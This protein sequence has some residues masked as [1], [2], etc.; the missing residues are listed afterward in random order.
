MM[1]QRAVFYPRSGYMCSAFKSH[2]YTN[3]ALKGRYQLIGHRITM[4]NILFILSGNLSTT[5]RARKNIRAAAKYY[6]V[7]VL[8]ANRHPAWDKLDENWINS[9]D[10]PVEAVHLGRRPFFPWLQATLLHKLAGIAWYIFPKSVFLNAYASQKV[11]IQL[12]KQAKCLAFRPDLVVGQGGGALYPAYKFARK[13]RIPFAVDVEDYHPG[14]SSH[15]PKGH[16][17]KRRKFLL[18]TILPHAAF[19][20][21]ASPL[22]KQYTLN[23]AERPPRNYFLLNNA[24]PEHEFISARPVNDEKLQLVWF[25]QNIDHGRGLE[26]VISAVATY[27]DAVDLT[28]IGNARVQFI[29]EWLEPHKDYVF[30][31]DPKPQ[32]ELHT[33]LSNFDVGLATEISDCDINKDIALSNKIFAYAQAGLYILAT[34]TAGQKLF[35]QSHQQ[36]GMLC[37]QKT[38]DLREALDNLIRN[39]ES[40]RRKATERYQ[41]AK[42]LAWENEREKFL[43]ALDSALDK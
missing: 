34:D 9:H 41:Y 21:F 39:K 38:D 20:S 2:K 31:E 17:M 15:D 27:Q 19:V 23:V 1:L 18:R 33:Y 13:T 35:I 7:Y 26:L 40:I 43:R 36:L 24:F 4:K 22:I 3:E 10:Y 14:E 5:P 42:T 29:E 30:W 16:E 37:G 11:S 8:K 6:R 28:L 25:S 32:E 12:Y